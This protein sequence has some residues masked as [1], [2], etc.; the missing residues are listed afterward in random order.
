MRL[1]AHEAAR[2]ELV[3][4][5]AEVAELRGIV[6]RR[7]AAVL[8]GEAGIGKS[9][10]IGAATEGLATSIGG[11]FGMLRFIPYLPLVRAVG[12]LP[13]RDPASVAETV[14]QRVGGGVLVVDDLHWADDATLG[15]LDRI[16]G[17]VPV[18]AAVRTGDPGTAAALAA[19]RA[20]GL[21]ELRVHPLAERETVELA[22]RWR[23]ELSPGD[24]RQ[25]VARSG[26]NPLLVV[27]LARAGVTTTLTLAIEHRLQ[28]L[29][30]DERSVLELL[31][32]ADVPL[33]F[34]GS[35]RTLARL[36]DHG[37]VGQTDEGFAIRHA[38]IAEVIGGRLSDPRQ[39]ALHRQVAGL[40]D[41]PATR[42]RHLMAAGDRDAAFAVASAAAAT[43][44][45][46][47]RAALLGLAAE[48]SRG[49]EAPRLR[50]EAAEALI[51]A[52]LIEN[53]ERALGPDDGAEGD[54]AVRRQG[55]RGQI[56]YAQG[57][58]AGALAAIGEAIALA[59]TGSAL[60]ASLLVEQ[61]W[62]VTLRREGATAVAL[63]RK[64]LA[65]AHASGLPDAAAQ[66]VLGVAVSIVG[67]D[68]DEY[69][70]LY[71]AAAASARAAGDIAEEL[72]CGKLLVA[73]HESGD[74]ALGI[75]IGETFA[76]RAAEEGML[77]LGQT[78]RSSLVSIVYSQGDTARAVRDGEALLGESIDIRVRSA[79]AGWVATALVDLGRL[80]EARRT[81][82]AGLAIA[83]D[84]IEGCFDLRWAEAELALAEGRTADALRLTD[85]FVARFGKADYGD[86]SF[87][88][89]SHDWAHVE[90][91]RPLLPLGPP[92]R[93]LHRQHLPTFT[94]RQALRLLAA[95]DFDAAAATFAAAAD[96]FQPYH[97]R[98]ELRCRWATGEALRRGGRIPE[99]L[100]AL[101]HAEHLA[102]DRWV[103]LGGRIR[104]SL[105]L[106][107]ARRS[108]RRREAGTLTARER[109]ILELVA[110]G[111]TNSQI[112]ARLGIT[113][114]TVATLLAN[115]AAKLG[116]RSRVQTALRAA[117]TA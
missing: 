44:P 88:Y 16:A 19:A 14:I 45:A 58:S 108:A 116:T 41:D 71:E 51:S 38:L 20:A 15:I 57:D 22:R 2:P 17:R 101:E 8:V 70:G 55:I 1:A 77:A 9:S 94:E 69:V 85:E 28:A 114:R 13:E 64:A 92:A 5:A 104:R 34:P 37:L 109:E 86:M 52:R 10:L 90:L 81:I 62:I 75:R 93:S 39:R 53:A 35:P 54:L 25:L 73:S 24:F 115:A 83:P 59:T 18:L 27:E 78:I 33:A 100:K 98:S 111:L 79:T 103:P 91:S 107:G 31:A 7:G 12:S 102:G 11:A 6:D 50:V 36:V 113:S 32:I 72:F 3:G 40:T 48:C 96:A 89:V 63:A 47:L 4:R 97:R 80:E 29:S 105:R 68:F 76:A 74:Q 110:A 95:G 46:G 87:M 106:A 99:A 60:E 117:E 26:G 112:A 84:D 82:G 65:A 42:A 67:G 61:A 30:A 23:P 66:R 49:P 43:S 56:R 21:T